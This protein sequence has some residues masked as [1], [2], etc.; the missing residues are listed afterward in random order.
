MSLT[1]LALILL[2]PGYLILRLFLPKR[3]PH[4]RLRLAAIPVLLVVSQAHIIE[5]LFFKSVAGPDMPAWL[6]ILQTWLYVALL[7]AFVMLLV[8]D[9]LRLCARLVRKPPRKDADRE[10]GFSP[11][12]RALLRQGAGALLAS[13]VVPAAS[14]GLS[15]WGVARGCAVPEVRRMTLHLPDLPPGLDGLVIAHL[16][17]L[18]IGPLTS[19]DWTRQVVALANAARP[20]LVCLT[21]DLTDGRMEYRIPGPGT[22]RDA[23]RE[24]TGLSASLGVFGCPGNHEYYSDFAGW[25]AEYEKAGIRMLADAGLTLERGGAR[26]AL[27]GLNDAGNSCSSAAPTTKNA[28]LDVLPRRGDRAFRLLMDHRP[29]RAAANAEAGV[30]LQLSGHTHG[31]QCLGMDGLVARYNRGFVR[32]WYK[33]AGMALYVTAGAGLWPGCPV[34]MGVPAEIAVITLKRGGEAQG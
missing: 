22:R 19:L 30:D 13:V 31:G 28:V 16:A 12:R 3:R 21:G 20:D 29:G 15:G 4:L 25:M 24:L 17:D 27:A 23:V 10:T 8:L 9:A 26:L 5:A 34:R 1:S 33:V 6:L 2:P 7:L 11:E 18:H 14:L 32:G